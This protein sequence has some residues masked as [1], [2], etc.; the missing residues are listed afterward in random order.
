MGSR[1]VNYFRRVFPIGPPKVVGPS[2][3][4]NF[5]TPTRLTHSHAPEALFTEPRP[6]DCR[7]LLPAQPPRSRRPRLAGVAFL[8]PVAPPMPLPRS[9]RPRL[10]GTAFPAA[11]PLPQSHRPRLAG[12]AP[13]HR[14][15]LRSV[16]PP[17]VTATTQPGL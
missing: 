16:M 13:P 3:I 11:T 6:P 17:L 1:K 9:H 5:L 15:F 4:E 7:L 2:E 14:G 8:P 12:D 10:A